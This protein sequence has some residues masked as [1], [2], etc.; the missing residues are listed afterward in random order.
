LAAI[1]SV[2]IQSLKRASL[3]PAI[4]PNRSEEPTWP[5]GW[6]SGGTNVV[7]TV[8][9]KRKGHSGAGSKTALEARTAV[10]WVV[11]CEVAAGWKSTLW[12]HPDRFEGHSRPEWSNGSQH[13]ACRA[14]SPLPLGSWR[15]FRCLAMVILI[16]VTWVSKLF[17]GC[18][19]NRF[20]GGRPGGVIYLFIFECEKTLSRASDGG[21]LEY[22]DP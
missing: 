17:S 6:M 2:P 21:D 8:S 22:I 14:C 9:G 20:S 16:W 11:G 4:H 18:H 1:A 5:P 7:A 3:P 10:L 12:R 19:R 15:V 13:P